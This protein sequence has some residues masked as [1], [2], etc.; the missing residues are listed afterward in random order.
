M[1]GA[2]GRDV[3]EL[4]VLL[5][6]EGSNEPDVAFDPIEHTDLRGIAAA[7][8]VDLDDHLRSCHQRIKLRWRPCRP[9][10]ARSRR[11]VW[12]RWP[13]RGTQKKVGT[14]C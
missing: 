9:D 13:P 4:R 5:G 8:I 12:R 11:P 2:F 10:G 6:V 7:R 1:D 3:Q 14:A